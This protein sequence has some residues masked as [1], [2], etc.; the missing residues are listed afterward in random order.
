MTCR[1]FE[2]SGVTGFVCSRGQQKRLPKFKAV[3]LDDNSEEVASV[4]VIAV[5]Q[6][7]AAAIAGRTAPYGATFV[8]V[9]DFK[10]SLI[11]FDPIAHAVRRVRGGDAPTGNF[12]RG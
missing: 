11:D 2:C 1:P 4:T 6:K 8:K 5:S 7:E 12:T 9:G 3:Y 10:L